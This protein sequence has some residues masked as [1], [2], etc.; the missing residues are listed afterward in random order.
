MAAVRKRS[1]ALAVN[2]LKTSAPIGAALAFLGMARAIPMLHGSQGCAAFAKVFLVRHFREPIP[3]QTSAM[4]QVATIMSADDNVVEGLATICGKSRPALVGLPTTGLSETQGTDIQRVVRTFRAAHPQFDAIPVVPVNTPD[5]SG[6]LESGYAAAVH[7]MID[8]LVPADTSAAGRADRRVNVLAGASLTPGD[9][10]H[11]KELIGAFGLSPVVFP[12]LSDSLDGHLPAE[13][14]SPL[15]VG[16]TRVG[17]VRTLG[18]AMATLVIGRSLSGAA[19]LL[20]ART[21]V[22][23]HRFDHL[24]GLEAM[25]A[26]VTTL[27]AI[28]G[29]PVPA[30]I[31]RQRAQLQD[32]LV[33]THFALGFARVAVAAEPDL[34]QALVETLVASGA[35]VVAAVAPVAAPLLT[36]LP[37]A[38]VQIGDLEDLE[39]SARTAGAAL[40]VGNSHA[41]E[42]S[43]RLAVPLLRAGFPQ[44]DYFG[45]YQKLWV[46]YRG[47]RQ[48]LFDIA[49]LLL[50]HGHHGIRPYRSLLASK[51][52]ATPGARAASDIASPPVVAH[53][54]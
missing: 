13:E 23:D 50:L 29:R 40:V 48:T 7:A 1:K 25:D 47:T 8:V 19:D 21:G 24:M 33:D 49:N 14:F 42:T 17:D 11:V 34:L 3:L 53:A 54:V 30:G 41:A 27:A 46:G 6:S 39:R 31:A 51:D 38:E 37:V 36:E 2:P 4:D 35:E 22:P 10:E 44:Y 5:F 26:F 20:R 28:A 15:T 32:A 45:G 16:G 12:D 9:L 18:T 52:P 43:R